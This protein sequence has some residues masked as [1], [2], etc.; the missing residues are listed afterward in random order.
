M[1]IAAEELKQDK[2]LSRPENAQ[3]NKIPTWSSQRWT[4]SPIGEYVEKN[5]YFFTKI[6]LTYCEKK[7]SNDRVK[8][9]KFETE[10]RE[11]AKYLRSLEQFTPTMKGQ[12]NFW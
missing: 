12:N 3:A 5:W 2:L 6:V 7:C 1:N 10:G 8:L 9:L 4:N 11:C